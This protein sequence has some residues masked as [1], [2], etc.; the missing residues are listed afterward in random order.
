MLTTESD[1]ESVA[2]EE[3]VLTAPEAFT[4]E[5]GSTCAWDTVDL[6]GD[7]S[8]G[9]LLGAA[10]DRINAVIGHYRDVD[11]R[12]IVGWTFHFGDRVL[13]FMNQGDESCIGRDLPLSDAYVEI[14]LEEVGPHDIAG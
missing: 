14:V 2:A 13:T 8:Y 11:H 6:A 9:V 7:D 4:L 3:R 5:S 1:G 10:L 12:A